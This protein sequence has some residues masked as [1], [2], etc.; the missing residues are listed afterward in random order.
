VEEGEQKQK[1]HK[2]SSPGTFHS[3][4][5]QTIFPYF[6]PGRIKIQLLLGQNFVGCEKI[7]VDLVNFIRFYG[8]QEK[9]NFPA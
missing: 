3:Q 1:Q 8:Y 7:T 2:K 5:F 6:L 4:T 9:G